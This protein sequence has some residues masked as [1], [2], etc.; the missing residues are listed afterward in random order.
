MGVVR[1]T[2]RTI[3]EILMDRDGLN[4]ASADELIREAQEELAYAI[5]INDFDRAEN[6]CS[7]YFG[8]EPDYLMELL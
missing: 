1:M 7:E 2:T 3:K 8:L 4:E 6:I 5:S